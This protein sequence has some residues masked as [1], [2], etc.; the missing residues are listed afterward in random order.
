MSHVYP[1]QAGRNDAVDARQ[2][3]DWMSMEPQSMVWLPVFHRLATSESCKHQVKCS[4]C[5]THPIIG[6]RY[7]H[8]SFLSYAMV[9]F[10]LLHLDDYRIILPS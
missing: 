9:L 6:L 7:I 2:F 5:K 1:L 3:M 8:H 10:Q 4:L